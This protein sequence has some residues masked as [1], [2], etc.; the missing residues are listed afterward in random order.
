MSKTITDE[1]VLESFVM[2][3]KDNATFVD[4]MYNF[5]GIIVGPNGGLTREKNTIAESPIQDANVSVTYR[6][7]D[8]NDREIEEVKV[9]DTMEVIFDYVFSGGIKQ[10]SEEGIYEVSIRK[11]LG[12]EVTNVQIG[13]KELKYVNS[14]PISTKDKLDMIFECVE[15]FFRNPG[16]FNKLIPASSINKIDSE[17][18]M[19]IYVDKG[20]IYE[21]FGKITS[22]ADPDRAYKTYGMGYFKKTSLGKEGSDNN[23]DWFIIAKPRI[24]VKHGTSAWDNIR[25][26]MHH[27][28]S[29]SG[30][31][32]SSNMKQY[33]VEGKN[34]FCVLGSHKYVETSGVTQPKT[35]TVVN[36]GQFKID[37]GKYYAR[38]VG[39]LKFSLKKQNAKRLEGGALLD[40]KGVSITSIVKQSI[41]EIGV[42]NIFKKFATESIKVSNKSPYFNKNRIEL[43]SKIEIVKLSTHKTSKPYWSFHDENM[44]SFISKYVFKKNLHTMQSLE[45]EAFSSEEKTKALANFIRAL[46]GGIA[47]SYI[48][49]TEAIYGN[50]EA[51]VYFEYGKEISSFEDIIMNFKIIPSREFKPSIYAMKEFIKSSLMSLCSYVVRIKYVNTTFDQS[52]TAK[53]CERKDKEIMV[54]EQKYRIKTHSKTMPRTP[55]YFPD[56]TIT[57]G[58]ITLGRNEINSKN[59]QEIWDFSIGANNKGIRKPSA[60][61]NERD[62]ALRS[63]DYVKTETS[64]FY[65]IFFKGKSYVYGTYEDNTK[66]S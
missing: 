16:A 18:I 14:Q 59:W 12:D 58:L 55:V 15:F 29:N 43:I 26:A 48:S 28:T 41:G 32:S 52:L 9:I 57:N 6:K 2:K 66:I 1:T 7:K 45:K 17:R 38:Y 47:E 35:D 30:N 51:N 5:F 20:N 24:V 36:I 23:K 11:W 54:K 61:R 21:M 42:E 4:V 27:R 39:D 10:G 64:T 13:G 56:A 25:E 49:S 19:A 65:V 60:F 3:N 62:K 63:G 33:D 53:M 50:W 46:Y 31:R 22:M 8:I 34:D 37:K 44:L 40:G